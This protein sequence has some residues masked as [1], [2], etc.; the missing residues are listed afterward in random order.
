MKSNP[1]V[2]KMVSQL[3]GHVIVCNKIFTSN[4]YVFILSL[5]KLTVILATILYYLIY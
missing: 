2:L 5:H 1:I 4:K 3:L